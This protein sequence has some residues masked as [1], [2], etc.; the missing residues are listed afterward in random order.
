MDR[1]MMDILDRAVDA[2]TKRDFDRMPHEQELRTARARADELL[3]DAMAVLSATD[4]VRHAKAV[5]D[6]HNTVQLAL[7]IRS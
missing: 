5:V 6:L 1:K 2:A 3:N 7:D 4:P